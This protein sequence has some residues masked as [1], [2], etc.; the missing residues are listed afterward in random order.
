MAYCFCLAIN[1]LFSISGRSM[2]RTRTWCSLWRQT[3]QLVDG[4]LLCVIRDERVVPVNHMVIAYTY[5]IT[6]MFL[7]RFVKEEGGRAPR[8]HRQDEARLDGAE[9]HQEESHGAR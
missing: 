6:V 9:G 1:C 3:L 4:H 7:I 2:V 8:V 5:L